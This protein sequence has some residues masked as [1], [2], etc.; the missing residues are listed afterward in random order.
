[1][2]PAPLWRALDEIP[3]DL[4][5]TAVAIGNFDGV[6]RGHRAVLAIL[7][8]EASARG[9]AAVALTFWPHPR[10]VCVSPGN[11]TL[12]TGARERAARLADT[13]LSGVL[14]LPFT[15]DFAQLSA[16][17]F[18]RTVLVEGLG[19]RLI[20]TGRDARFGRANEGDLATMQELGERFGFDVVVVEPHGEAGAERVSST[21]I[22]DLLEIDGDVVTAARMMG[23]PHVVIDTVRHGYK[24]GR[25]LG[26]PTANLG[27]DPEG[28][29]PRDGV[30]AGRVTVLEQTLAH[31]GRPRL[32]DAP[33]TIS[34]G[35][36]PT[37]HEEGA[38]GQPRVVE[39]YIHTDQPVEALDLYGDTVRVEFVELQRPT[40]R[41]DS[42]DALVA[43]MEEDKD[44]T[45]RTLERH[46]LLRSQA[47]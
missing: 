45:V 1:M 18:V 29:V 30:Y 46:G 14:E 12:I 21:A 31:A 32:V 39:A 6:H 3:A 10:H 42:V 15:W 47:A 22:R 24:R 5:P 8:G 7:E 33:A 19:M 37:F 2:P 17:D 28:M 4:G 43:Q 13:G 20:V 25:E 40:L 9:L 34:V 41:F 26:F 23:E 11:P 27:P 16:E 35:T 38:V 36:N 44:V